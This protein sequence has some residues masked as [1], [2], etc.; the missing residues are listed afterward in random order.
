MGIDSLK[1][2]RKNRLSK[3]KEEMTKKRAYIPFGCTLLDLSV[4]GGDDLDKGGMGV[5]V[6]DMVNFFG[7]TGV[8][9]S[10]L[11]NEF[12][13][14]GKHMVESG[15]LQKFGINKFKYYYGDA[16][17]ANNFDTMKLYGFEV[18][19]ADKVRIPNT[20]EDYCYHIQSLL[21]KLKEDEL[22]IYVVDSLDVLTS[23]KLLAMNDSE[24]NAFE[25]G[26]EENTGSMDLQ[27]NKFLA[28]HFFTPIQE[29]MVG[30]NMILLVVSQI[31]EVVGAKPFEKKTT[32]SNTKTLKFYFD[33]RVELLPSTKIMKTITLPESGEEF[34]NVIGGTVTAVPVKVRHERPYRKVQFEYFHKIG[35]DS[36]GSN[37]DYL[38]NLRDD[39]NKI[40]TTAMAKNLI[41]PPD[42]SKKD[43]DSPTV[44]N[45][46]EWVKEVLPEAGVKST[47]TKAE[48]EEVI[49]A[50]NLYKQFC[51]KFGSGLARDGIIDYIVDNN[52]EEELTKLV[53][54]KWEAVEDAMGEINRKKKW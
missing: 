49:Q 31:R 37:V 26:K 11:F 15:Q 33:T 1:E 27:K 30:K 54:A 10:F 7:D 34:T 39:Q 50:N 25:K 42:F 13:A 28:Q 16:E 2:E 43:Y 23:R 40:R 32:T 20:V 22:L 46:R 36:V 12:I 41:F 47:T 14:R 51:D 38:Y 18:H 9:K 4:G 24:V 6:G 53:I 44:P 3:T 5:G 48:L 19:P 45:I 8:G 17:N 21:K 29:A 52:L 35:L